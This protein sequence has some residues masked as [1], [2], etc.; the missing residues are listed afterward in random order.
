M[1]EELS[2]AVITLDFAI[3]TQRPIA[4]RTEELKLDRGMDDTVACDLG[5]FGDLSSAMFM[6][7]PVMMMGIITADTKVG[8]FDFTVFFG[9]IILTEFANDFLL[10]FFV[11]VFFDSEVHNIGG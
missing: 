5:F 8:V 9:N 6:T 2:R 11:L 3:D 4:L 1:H 10:Q 7:E